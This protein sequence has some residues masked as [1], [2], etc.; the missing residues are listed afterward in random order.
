MDTQT[1]IDKIIKAIS[2]AFKTDG[3]APGLT[4]AW[5]SHNKSYYTSIIRWINGEK[6]VVCTSADEKLNT[7][8]K[9]LIKRFLEKN[10]S[11]INPIEELSEYFL[12]MENM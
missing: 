2:F 10:P 11:P 12:N 5:I 4:I 1:L 7:A 8:L 3:T 9:L 6:D